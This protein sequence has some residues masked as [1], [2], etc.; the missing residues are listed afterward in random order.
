MGSVRAF[1]VD[2]INLK[3]L[4]LYLLQSPNFLLKYKHNSTTLWSFPSRSLVSLVFNIFLGDLN[5]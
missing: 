5:D 4:P 1:Y 2:N 3:S